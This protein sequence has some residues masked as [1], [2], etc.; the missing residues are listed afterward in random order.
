MKRLH[1]GFIVSALLFFWLSAC[2]PGNET[3]MPLL[4]PEE[5]EGV[6]LDKE[7]STPL[8]FTLS[9]GIKNADIFVPSTY[10]QG[11]SLTD[12]ELTSLLNRLPALV[13][14]LSDTTDFNFPD[15][16]IP[17]PRP[18]E[19][20]EESFPP[21]EDAAAIDVEYGVLE[22][23]RYSPEGEI[24]IAPFV[25]I[26]FNQPMVPLTTIEELTEMDVPVQISPTLP[27]TWRWLGTKTLNFQYDSELIDRLPMATEYEVLIPV[28]IESAVGG[29][30]AESVSFCFNTPAPKMQRYHPWGEPQP[31]ESLFFISFD[32]RIDPAKVLEN[33][34]VNADSRKVDIKLATEDEIADD[35]TVSNLVENAQ[36]SRYLVFRTYESLPADAEIY[37]TVE[38]GAPSA[39]GPL[40][41]TEA[42]SYSFYTYAPLKLTDHR[43]GWGDQCRPLMPLTIE[44]NNPI[45]EEGF[46]EGML[47]ISPELLGASVDVYGNTVQITGVTEGRTTYKVKVSGEIKDIFGQ[48]LGKDEQVRFKIGSAEPF[49]VG[50]D[51]HFITLDPAASDPSIS[52]YLMN[53]KKLDVQIYSVQ[54]SDWQ[55]FLTY[56]DEYRWTDRP[57]DPPGKLLL[58][59]TRSL[60]TTTDTLSEVNLDLSEFI[61][62]DFGHFVVI[63]KPHKG[64][65]EEE[66][67]W[68][69]V[70][71]W[72]QV[73]QIGLDAFSDH[74]EL[75]VWATALSDGTPL[76]GVKIDDGFA[77]ITAVT[78]EDGIAR[79]ELPI[80]GTQYLLAQV[81]DDV[82]MLPYSTY[83]SKDENGWIHRSVS[84]N[85]RWFV[86]DDR[87]MYRPGEE[88]HLKG[89]I[90]QIGG[91]QLGDIGL[92]GDALTG[93]NYSLI[94]AQGNE[95]S[96]GR[97]NVNLLGGFDIAF[98]IPENVNLG[99]AQLHFQA[100]D[101]F[102]QMENSNYTHSFQIQEF[103]RP[104]FEVSAR[105]ETEAPYFV[106]EHAIFAVEAKYYA[107]GA[108]MNAETNWWVNSNETNY[109]PPNWDKFTFG[110]WTPWWYFGDG[111]YEEP[112]SESFTGV[113]D[114]TGTHFLRIDF[115]GEATRPTSITAEATVMDLNR[116]AWTSGT[117]LLLHPADVYVGLRSERYFVER[118]KPLDI[119]LIVTDLDGNAIPDRSVTVV[120]SRIQWKSQGGWHEEFIDPQTC[121]ITSGLDPLT[122]TFDTSIGGRYRIIALVTDEQ[123]RQNESRIT[124]WVS[125][126]QRPPSREVEKEE[127]TLI[128]D[129]DEYQPGDVAEIL[130]QTPFTPAEILLT[131]SRSGILYTERYLIEEGTLT[132]SVPISDEQI[133]NIHLQVDAVGAAPRVDD[134]GASV[135][136]VPARPAYAS[137]QL[138]LSIP[139]LTRT[140]SVDATLADGEIE[141]GGKTTLDLELKDSAGNPVANAELAV[142]V[143]D[144]SILALTNYQLADPVSTFY[145][146]RSSDLSSVYGRASIVLTNPLALTEAVHGDELQ[147]L[148]TASNDAFKMDGEGAVMEEA[149]AMPAA[150]QMVEMEADGRGGG[151]ADAPQIAVRSN[152]NPLATFEAEVHTDVNGKVSIQIEVPDNLTRY[153]VMVVAVDAGGKQF[154]KTETNL[155]ARLPLMVRPS[156]PRF[157]NFGDKFEFPIL[158]QNQTN[159]PI[160][161]DVALQA[162]NITLPEG[163][164]Q[165]V[166]V[167]ANDRVEVR[168]SAETEMA[169]IAQ[170][171]IGAVSGSYADAA[172]LEIPVYTPAT[173]EA[174]A[175]Y[176]V[177]DS[178]AIA[179]PIAKPND[180]YAQFGGLEIQTSSTALQTL[181]DAV[182]YLA[183]YPYA[184]TEQLSSRILGIATLKDVLTAFQ[185]EGLPSADEMVASVNQD[186]TRLQGIQNYDGGFP[187]WR[188]GQDSIPFNTIHVAHA[189]QR[190]KEKGFDIPAEMQENLRNYL[191]NIE[192]H[193]PYWY[194]ETTRRVLSS[195]ALYVRDLMGD[196]DAEKALAL[197]EDAPLEE[198]SFEAIAWLW[199]VL[200][201]D[202]NAT[203]ELAEIRLYI[204]NHVVETAGEA[205][206][207]TS[208][209]DQTYLILSSDR[210][211]DAIL[212]DALVA[213]DP[214][215]DLIPKLVKGLL[216][217]RTQGRWGSTQENVFVLLAMDRYFNTYESQTPDFVAR[218]WL[219]ETYA[220]EHAYE[221]YSTERHET[222]IP[223]TYLVNGTDL[224]DLTLSKEGIGRL[225]YRLGLKY[226]PIDLNLDP[227]DMGFVVIREY[228][229]VDEP[230]EVWQDEDGVWHIKAGTRVRI[231]IKMVADNRRY[232]VALVD[233]L[234]A[235]LEIIDPDL[236]VSSTAP[237]E[238]SNPFEMR[239]GWWW[240]GTWYE[241]QNLRD[242]RAEAFT[243]LLWNGVYDYSYIARA[244]TPGTFIAPPAKAEEMYSPEVFGRS[245]SD[246]V[247]VE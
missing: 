99:Y 174:F 201:D 149:M 89:W 169:G 161:V 238:N 195:Y 115:A 113:T 164:G 33:I 167:P 86:Y 139:P 40:L 170:F 77:Q 202:P 231:K 24:P 205:N 162:T 223:M 241:H 165:R 60:D 111:D 213:D 227:L 152:F 166:I 188:R 67:Y 21:E 120:A 42:Q 101:A 243:S 14:G 240:W 74:S 82:A 190:A 191:T 148:A 46:T 198:L 26:T 109:S 70:H 209:D 51:E 41:T 199:Q 141:P 233:P 10:V 197:L 225:Y 39:E 18:G 85:M 182:M 72:A 47:E 73:T 5:S 177:V 6:P 57:Q 104:E 126:G 135:K 94:G 80:D 87:A 65:F 3:P 124:R 246:W 59:E 200:M 203:A 125:G 173:S 83:Y 106:G 232:H 187:Y 151:A 137:G 204:N 69:T 140:L 2:S 28:G 13:A 134:A 75:V 96:T 76:S 244:T 229:G 103:R 138:N 156:A 110:F 15:E 168:F 36:E 34:T 242:E 98:S 121:E 20:L 217:H 7:E 23:L 239:Y 133:P 117:S 208:Y 237:D 9:E 49:L 112:Q 95:L 132:L 222:N 144:E 58:D 206:F 215:S 159:E 196:N 176:G 92:I 12:E 153:R 183:K 123:G 19:T 108:L 29:V 219:G 71:V 211:A 116:Q 35:E 93:V 100:Q 81:G 22:V 207:T 32:Q 11:E 180:V 234:P 224:I 175:T 160:E 53:Y 247:V 130:V 4:M 50:P 143:V 179:Q 157:L 178:G 61:D 56:L 212:L 172:T 220:G 54:P 158:I 79:F 218:I 43:C 66:N 129:K 55:T 226:A 131:V 171:Q 210:R 221:G 8:T 150:A 122:C 245:G 62:G 37:V 154:G 136:D 97:V 146:Q 118:G 145:S 30:L 142:V 186:V 184:C 127:I 25:N 155:T 27:G 1:M 216:A 64:L 147:A 44:F 68:E 119:E 63:V 78:G 193:Y 52:L 230:E 31:L 45:D 16:A 90:R 48:M 107:G 128:P 214:K 181:T 235:G 192:S 17:P 105:N 236:A 194:S 102:G 88:V 163:A 185:A 114:S 84:D 189:L 38:A 228:E 91:G